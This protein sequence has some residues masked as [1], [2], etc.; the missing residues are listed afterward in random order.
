[1]LAPAEGALVGMGPAGIKG[2]KASWKRNI[3]FWPGKGN[4]GQALLPP[5]PSQEPGPPE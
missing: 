4:Q 3:S 1:M 5:C 2:K